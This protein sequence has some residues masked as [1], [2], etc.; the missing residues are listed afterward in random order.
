MEKW[1]ETLVKV[2][3][4]LMESR[5]YKKTLLIIAEQVALLSG[6]CRACALL[7]DGGGFVIEAGFPVDGHG[8]NAVLTPDTGEGF[9]REIIANGSIVVVDEP[10]TDDRT[11]YMWE[12]AVRYD[13]T[14]V[15]FIPLTY[16][17][18][19]LGA[20]VLDFCNGKC[21]NE[22]PTDRIQLLA[23]LASS[24]I[25][26]EHERRRNEVKI[27][28]MERM[29]AIGEQ[30]AGI[31]HTIRNGLDLKIGAWARRMTKKLAGGEV[32]P[33]CLTMREVLESGASIILEEVEALERFV[34]DLLRFATPEKSRAESTP[35]NAFLL[36]K[37][38]RVI[39]VNTEFDLDRRLEEMSV[40]MDPDLVSVVI[41]DLTKN[42][43]QA[44]VP[45]RE[46][47]LTVR[48][49]YS[50]R[51]RCVFI[52]YG[53]N[54]EKIEEGY[55]TD[56]FSPFFTTKADGTGLGLPHA[57][58]VLNRHGGDIRVLKSTDEQ[59]VFEIMLPVVQ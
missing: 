40:K 1:E 33:E 47:L 54:G 38:R 3:S 31:A 45:E 17:G 16:Q 26:S 29:N 15:V 5:D 48:T 14:K 19:N 39:G 21:K 44:Q 30:V 25:G 8:I 53:N 23:N 10:K 59:T 28:R 55:M 22:L 34:N 11:R 18:E 57:K 2:S 35:I 56:I 49:R 37:V 46:L 42:A 50:Q 24:A 7:E 20:L 32:D 9:L 12:L 43:L 36:E 4:L 13:M 52:Q 27:L 6:A 58:A 51:Q 41:D